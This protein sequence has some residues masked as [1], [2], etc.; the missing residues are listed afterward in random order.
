MSTAEKRGREKNKCNR[1]IKWRVGKK[2]QE[3][4]EQREAIN[5]ILRKKKKYLYIKSG[6]M[7]SYLR[8]STKIV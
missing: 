3:L 8:Q 2:I 7:H 4:V 1:K 5:E 6:N